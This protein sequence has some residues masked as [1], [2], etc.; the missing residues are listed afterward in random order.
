MKSKIILIIVGI[1]L[2]IGFIGAWIVFN[3]M[4]QN[5]YGAIE[6]NNCKIDSDCVV[7]D[8]DYSSCSCDMK[9]VNQGYADYV[10]SERVKITD[11]SDHCDMVCEMISA[12]CVNGK[13][14]TVI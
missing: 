3:I 2:L 6:N 1:I 8:M 13:C 14:A 10:G 11:F 12:E 4:A 9:A 5:G 7:I